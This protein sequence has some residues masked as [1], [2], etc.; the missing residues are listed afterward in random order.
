MDNYRLIHGD[1]IASLEAMP[2][3]VAHALCT[4]VPFWLQRDYKRKGAHGRED[5]R[6]E[7]AAQQVAV[8][9]EARRVLRSDASA[10]VVVGESHATRK[11][12][13]IKNGEATLQ[14]PYLAERLREDGWWVKALVVL[15]F[16]NPTPSSPTDRPRQVHQYGIMLAASQDFFWDHISSK[17]PGLEYNVLLRSVWSGPRENAYRSKRIKFKHTSTYP[18]WVPDRYLK[19]AVSEGGVCAACGAPWLPKIQESSG[20]SKGKSWHD[21]QD[22][23][24]RGNAKTASSKDYV[25]AKITGWRRGCSCKKAEKGRPL[26]IDPFTGTSTTGVAA[27]DLGCHYV[28]IDLDHRCIRLSKERLDGHLETLSTP[29]FDSVKAGRRQAELFTS[30]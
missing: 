14:G 20:G 4:S 9:H 17:R 5:A 6:E 23:S 1:A 21:H 26:V 30:D 19:G 24:F 10:F 3:G 2:S 12:G 16:D 22:D 7:W 8:M 29:L 13:S 27:L 11:Y 28:G 15:E 25:P 18:R